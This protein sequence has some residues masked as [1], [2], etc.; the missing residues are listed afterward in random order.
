MSNPFSLTR[1]PGCLLL[2]AL[3][4]FM[5]GCTSISIPRGL[6]PVT[7][8]EL[9]RYL[10]RWYEI[11]RL[12]HRFERGLDNVFAEYTARPDGRIA[13]L[14]RGYDP[15]R[16]TWRQARGVAHFIGDRTTASLAVC[17]FWPFYGGYHVIVLDRKNYAHAM[18]A[19]PSRDYLWILAREPQLPDDV[20]DALLDQA[21]AWGFPTDGIIRVKQDR[22]GP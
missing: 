21:R 20:T 9:D 18:V 15:V 22:A 7:G 11:A 12:D 5:P 14:N 8:F 10:G 19:G 17:F 6:T 1:G 2:T 3:I 4:M 13:V 16:N